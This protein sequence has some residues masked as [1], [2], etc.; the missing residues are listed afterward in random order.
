MSLKQA[1][2]RRLKRLKQVKPK[3]WVG[4]KKPGSNSK[5]DNE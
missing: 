5:L 4:I 3:T 2:K 1:N